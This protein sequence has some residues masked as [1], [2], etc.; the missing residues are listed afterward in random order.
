VQLFWDFQKFSEKKSFFLILSLSFYIQKGRKRLQNAPAPFIV[1]SC[2]GLPP[3]KKAGAFPFQEKRLRL[4][5]FFDC[6]I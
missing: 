3:H 4:I 1:L 6:L 2:S 5:L